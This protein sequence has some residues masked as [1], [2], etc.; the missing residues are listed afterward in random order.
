[1]LRGDS[2]FQTDP[3]PADLP[4]QGLAV[5]LVLEARRFFCDA[6]GCSRRI[7]AEPFPGLAAPKGRRS[8]RLTGLF[9]AI[10]VALGGEAGARLVGDLGM[11][12]SPDTLLRL[13]RALPLPL[14]VVPR[15]VGIDDWAWRR[16]R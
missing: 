3:L 13:V 15:V 9:Q 7:F 6:T 2:R 12:T 4:W 14:A 5:S 8:A 16:G 11:T 1:M 10:G